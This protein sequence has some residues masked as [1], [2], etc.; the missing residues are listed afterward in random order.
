M[1]KLI[2]RIN[3]E[4]SGA[5]IGVEF[6]NSSVEVVE[7]SFNNDTKEVLVTINQAILDS[8]IVNRKMLANESNKILNISA[9]SQTQFIIVVQDFEGLAVDNITY[10]LFEI[11][12]LDNTEYNAFELSKLAH[13]QS[14]LFGSGSEKLIAL[15]EKIGF[16]RPRPNK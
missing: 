6:Y 9:V 7:T 3:I 15:A 2:G 4:S 1:N 16:P 8:N 5:T 14:I 11:D 12:V 13:A 10:S